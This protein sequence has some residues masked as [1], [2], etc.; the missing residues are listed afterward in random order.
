M[1]NNSSSPLSRIQAEMAVIQDLLR[2]FVVVD[3]LEEQDS[4]LPQTEEVSA[5]VDRL[6]QLVH[7]EARVMAR[8]GRGSHGNVIPI[9]EYFQ[10]AGDPEGSL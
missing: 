7:L 2:S 6:G 1:K 5:L 10:G 9:D 3:P 4:F 8:L